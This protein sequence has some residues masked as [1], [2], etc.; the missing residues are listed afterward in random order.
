MAAPKIQLVEAEKQARIPRSPSHTFRVDH[1][2]WELQQVAHIPVLPAETLKNLSI[3]SRAVSQPLVSPLIGWW[4]EYYVFYTTHRQLEQQVLMD[5]MLDPNV[6]LTASAANAR[7]FYNGKGYNWAGKVTET[8]VKYWFRDVDERS[9]TYDIRAGRPSVRTGME[10]FDQSFRKDSQVPV[11]SA[12]NA[13]RNE[14]ERLQNVWEFLRTSGFAKMSYEDFLES[15]GVKGK[16]VDQ[17]RPELI[18][19]TRDWQYPTNTI[20]PATGV[21][22]TACSWSIQERAD[23]DR[24]FAE[25][26]FIS[27]FTVARPKIYLSNQTSAAIASLDRAFRWLPAIMQGDPALS[28]AEFLPTDG[29]FG[30]ATGGLTE[31]YWL[32][33]RDLFVHGDQWIDATDT[34]TN[35]VALPTPAGVLKF[36]TEAMANSLFVGTT[37]P[38]RMVKQDGIVKATILGTQMDYTPA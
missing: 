22:T 33:M 36:P 38:T 34:T 27:V 26:G 2:P 8:I 18:R 32:D 6:N 10:R 17:K 12:Q 37:E 21:P 29:P 19:I 23:K 24:Y 25:P 35:S 4:L 20:N 3:Q 5:M 31:N 28:L 30:K 16:T 14:E 1:K 7:D 13:D 9:S 15:Y 11:G